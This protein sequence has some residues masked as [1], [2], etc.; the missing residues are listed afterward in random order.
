VFVG[1]LVVVR[2][3]TVE[4]KRM[5]RVTYP[6]R[7]E[8]RAQLTV[9]VGFRCLVPPSAASF[10]MFCSAVA[11]GDGVYLAQQAVPEVEK[12]GRNGSGFV[13]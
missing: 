11:V 4:E 7:L 9:R 1:G 13:T 3:G 2:Y 8:G 5:G 10:T 12:G 6:P